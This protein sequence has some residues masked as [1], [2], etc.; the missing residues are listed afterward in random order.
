MRG[1]F[2]VEI[3]SGNNRETGSEQI[4]FVKG[5]DFCNV[6]SCQ[7]ADSY[8]YI[9]RCEVGGS[10]CTTLFVGSKVNKQRVVRRKHDTESYAQHQSYK[11]EQICADIAVPLDYINAGR[12]EKKTADNNV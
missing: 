8:T 6:T 7:H 4:G 1:Y 9:P 12:K 3:K 5:A 10:G 11:E 2:Q